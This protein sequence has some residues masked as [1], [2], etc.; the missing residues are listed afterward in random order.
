MGR[1]GRPDKET[2]MIT[3]YVAIWKGIVCV[4]PLTAIRGTW[5]GSAANQQ[6]VVTGTYKGTSTAFTVIH[7]ATHTPNA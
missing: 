2:P 3:G 7:F 4:L 5:H 1:H 6:D